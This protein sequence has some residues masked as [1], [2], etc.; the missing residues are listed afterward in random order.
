MFFLTFSIN[1]EE[2]SFL[3][4]VIALVFSNGLPLDTVGICGA[5]ASLD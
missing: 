2:S 1:H 5:I 4:L 3:L